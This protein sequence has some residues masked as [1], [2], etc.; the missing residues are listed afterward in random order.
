MAYHVWLDR[1]WVSW[2]EI[3]FDI[4]Y[5]IYLWSY[6]TPSYSAILLKTSPG[7]IGIEIGGGRTALSCVGYY[8]SDH[9]LDLMVISKHKSFR[10]GYN[11][12][13]SRVQ[14]SLRSV[15]GILANSLELQ[16]LCGHQTPSRLRI[17]TAVSWK[18]PPATRF[19][20]T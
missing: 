16:F 4:R 6:D 19:L 15:M 20:Q 17:T 2:D 13:Q 18:R 11:P 10:P 14:D 8:L 1:R 9:L 12:C 3:S 7:G 5:T